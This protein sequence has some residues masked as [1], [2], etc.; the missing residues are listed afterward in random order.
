M[1]KTHHS[2]ADGLALVTLT[3]HLQDKYDVSQLPAMR[4]LKLHEKFIVYATLPFTITF[5]ALKLLFL[6]RDENPIHSISRPLSGIK[7]ASVSRDFLVSDLKA[8]SHAL[9]V[10]INDFIMTLTS[11]SLKEYLISQGDTK[12]N[13]IG[14]TIPI[15][16]REPFETP[17]EFELCNDFA[18]VHF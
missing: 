16:L 15:N 9:G 1:F 13:T 18:M 2:F 10:T 6:H 4:K 3:C 14:L 12:T 5:L 8:H 17:E 7:K 11:V